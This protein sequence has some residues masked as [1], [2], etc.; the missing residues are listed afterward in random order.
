MQIYRCFDVG[1][2]PSAE[3]APWCLIIARR[4]KPLQAWTRRCLRAVRSSQRGGTRP[5][6]DRVRAVFWYARDLRSGE[7]PRLQGSRGH[8]DG[9]SG[10]RGALHARLPSSRSDRGAPRANDLCAWPRAGSVRAP[11]RPMSSAGGHGFRERALRSLG[12]RRA[13]AAKKTS[14]RARVRGIW[15]RGW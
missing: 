7:A 9:R 5:C 2:Q 12:R 10:R 4:F 14:D 15:P 1:R 11:G 6:S 3:S 8:R 13:R